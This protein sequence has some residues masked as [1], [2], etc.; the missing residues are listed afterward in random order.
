VGKDTS[1]GD[2]IAGYLVATKGGLGAAMDDI[3]AKLANFAALEPTEANAVILQGIEIAGPARTLQRAGGWAAVQAK[4]GSGAPA[5]IRIRGW[6]DRLLDDLV[7]FMAERPRV[8]PAEA[9]AKA[10]AENPLPKTLTPEELEVERRYLALR[11]ELEVAD[12][13]R[14][15]SV[16]LDHPDFLKRH[17]A[18]AIAVKGLFTR[19]MPLAI[20]KRALVDL[21]NARLAEAGVPAIRTATTAV[22]KDGAHFSWF[23]IGDTP[24]WV[25]EFD[26][27]VLTMKVLPESE[28]QFLVEA[29]YH[30]AAH[31]DQVFMAARAKAG[32]DG[33]IE[34]L[35]R[36]MD[37][38]GMGLPKDIAA[39]AFEQRVPTGSPAAEQ[40]MK[41]YEAMFGASKP[42]REGALTLK[43]QLKAE[44]QTASSKLKMIMG[45]YERF[46]TNLAAAGKV[47]SD[48]E[49]EAQIGDAMT[50]CGTLRRRLDSTSE[51]YRGL[52]EERDAYRL[53]QAAREEYL[54]LEREFQDL[55]RRER[56][57]EAAARGGP[58]LSDDAP[59][60]VR[61]PKAGG[62]NA[63]GK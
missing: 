12:V 25:A 15:L 19:E 37:S 49:L 4:L 56:A 16:S 8:A 9:G 34:A 32:L 26:E 63:P 35:T 53:G 1:A 11:T 60:T 31:A 2:R 61:E 59:P 14:V 29:T 55:Q 43:R 47:A 20:R 44:L 48:P 40:G 57:A 33:N 41:Y 30:E 22:G 28:W 18:S 7:A 52:D 46:K 21:M 39:A 51:I 38:G 36:H 62:G 10:A 58:P 5:M 24:G 13:E 3:A 45:M 23:A 42:F 17:A 54:A 50:R 6:R 27:T